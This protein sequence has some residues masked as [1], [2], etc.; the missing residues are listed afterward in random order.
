MSEFE[1]RPKIRS[2]TVLF[3]RRDG[4]AAM[5]GDGQ[6]TLGET[7]LKGNARK[8]RRLS[9]G[10][11][12]AG[13]AGSTADAF[14]LL[15]RFETK[16]EQFQGQLERA[17]IELS[18]DWRTDK[19]LRNLEALIIV[20]DGRDAFLISGKGDVIAS[21]EGLL[22]VG[23]GGMYAMSAARALMNHT[24]LSARDIAEQSLKIAAD[25]C[26]YTNSDIVIEEV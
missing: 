10:N 25:I 6:V 20:A 11:V 7:V 21:D 4:K 17:A 22:A 24:Q 5:A 15:N 9:D 14:T 3:V 13:F 18:K 23:S 12:L 1:L 2:T 19:Y 26:I 16:L 8:I